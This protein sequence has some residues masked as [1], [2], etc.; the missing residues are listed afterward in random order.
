MALGVFGLCVPEADGV[1]E[2]A[3]NK[4]VAAGVDGEGGDG[5]VV[6]FEVADE[7]VVVGG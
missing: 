6:A 4:R 5:G 7:A 3:R 1:V 2:G